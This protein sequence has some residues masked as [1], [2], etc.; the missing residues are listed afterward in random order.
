MHL[1]AANAANVQREFQGNALEMFAILGPG[2]PSR[3][4]HDCTL[5]HCHSNLIVE[6]SWRKQNDSGGT[7]IRLSCSQVAIFHHISHFK[8]I[9]YIIFESLFSAVSNRR[10]LVVRSTPGIE[11][12]LRVPPFH[13]AKIAKANRGRVMTSPAAR[14]PGF[15]VP[16]L[17]PAAYD[18][19]LP[20][21]QKA[22]G[23]TAA[24]STWQS[25][26]QH[27]LYPSYARQMPRDIWFWHF[28]GLTAEWETR[29]NEI[30]EPRGFAGADPT[31][32]CTCVCVRVC[33]ST[34][35]RGFSK[36]NAPTMDI[37]DPKHAT[38]RTRDQWQQRRPASTK[39]WRWVLVD[40]LESSKFL[41]R[42]RTHASRHN[43][44]TLL[45][46]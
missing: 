8:K 42:P 13:A 40:L 33:V 15:L 4:S 43:L 2:M 31:R 3:S 5:R 10:P 17:A 29:R 1:H 37:A 6:L 12:R 26:R 24:E 46:L 23:V 20:R 14:A 9:L 27:A 32:V 22:R 19:A 38:P 45:Y 21:R 34:H 25:A 28:R 30:T 41:Y 44:V 39:G 35:L 18:A 16:Y 36:C 7:F 11:R